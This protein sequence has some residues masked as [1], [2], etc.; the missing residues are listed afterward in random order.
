MDDQQ[1][2]HSFS[3]RKILAT[4]SIG[5]FGGIIGLETIRPASA[6]SGQV[7]P[8]D[9]KTDANQN[10]LS[11]VAK[12][13]FTPSSGYEVGNSFFTPPYAE[14]DTV[15]LGDLD[16]RMHALDVRS[17]EQKWRYERPE[18]P[19]WSTPVITDET[20]VFAPRPE[21]DDDV[22]IHAVNSETGEQKWTKDGFEGQIDS[23]LAAQDGTIYVTDHGGH[24]YALDSA[25]GESQW[26]QSDEITARGR[27]VI[28]GDTIYVFDVD[29]SHVAAI[30]ID[31]GET[32]W[33]GGEASYITY[34]YV[35][36]AVT[37]DA[38]YAGSH[39]LSSIE[40]ESGEV[41]WT[42]DRDDLSITPH[43]VVDDG[44]VYA[45]DRGS[46]SST[47]YALDAGTGDNRWETE[48]VGGVM[49][50]VTMNG[51]L[52]VGTNNTN[53]GGGEDE[54]GGILHAIDGDSGEQLWSASRRNAELRLSLSPL[55]DLIFAA[56]TTGHLYAIEHSRDPFDTPTVDDYT[57]D[58]AERVETGGL[59][60]AID[61]WRDGEIDTDVLREVIDAWRS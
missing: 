8:S 29:R 12:W 39:R 56:G 25:N 50:V 1:R 22:Q 19:I 45:A 30:A 13:E 61:D 18:S 31:T 16:G 41:N 17:G 43:P 36:P 35:R 33:T 10:D 47:V 27:P 46:E 6:D 20:L 54:R 5:V 34:R 2:E 32:L 28:D 60:N 38:V 48:I 52:Y 26:V 9:E 55:D 40:K 14:D 53:A 37:E 57:D 21:N 24:L 4:A 7:T 59:R 42:F 51:V 15:Y 23:G 58:E 3:R 49:T 11:S 44:T